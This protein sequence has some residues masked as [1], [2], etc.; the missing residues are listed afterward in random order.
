M[1]SKAE[2]TGGMTL[3]SEIKGDVVVPNTKLSLAKGNIRYRVPTCYNKV[4][5]EIR[6]AKTFKTFKR[7][8]KKS[9][10]YRWQT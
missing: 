1:F 8:L 3:R 10:T 4:G 9:D 5:L 6:N 7:R 2:N